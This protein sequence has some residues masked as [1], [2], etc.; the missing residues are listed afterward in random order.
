MKRQRYSFSSCF[1]DGYLYVFG[2]R[3]YG[4]GEEAFISHCE[5]YNIEEKSWET[6]A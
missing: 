5:R 1:K 4:V 6:I 2:G 3:D